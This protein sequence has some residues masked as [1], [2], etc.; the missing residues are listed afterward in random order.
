MSGASSVRCRGHVHSRR[1]ISRRRRPG[2][3]SAVLLAVG[4]AVLS[5]AAATSG[6]AFVE[7]KSGVVI[8]WRRG[9]LS[10]TG[11]AAA[12]LR[13]PSADVARPGSER[14]ARA[15]AR[16]HLADALR[17]LPLGG[18]RRLDEAAVARAVT[19]ARSANVEYQSNGGAV[20]RMEV[21]FGDWAEVAAVLPPS[22]GAGARADTAGAGSAA[23]PE[24]AP[25]ALWLP[26]ARLGAAPVLVVAGREI[27]LGS[28]TYTTAAGLPTGTRPL[29]VHADKQ[30]KLVVDEG[31]NSRELAGRPAV[32]YVQK[33]L[34]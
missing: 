7:E 5:I 8:D 2:Q 23:T 18:G 21:S 13:M 15:A 24:P 30:G 11:G 26:E 14:R 31:G 16:T 4:G 10:A 3:L 34:R 32:I 6:D 12:D 29:T 28:A 19:R 27:T 20:V 22:A 17:T 33:V 25:V 9:T 1:V